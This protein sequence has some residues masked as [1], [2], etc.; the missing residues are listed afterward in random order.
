MYTPRHQA[1]SLLKGAVQPTSQGSM[2]LASSCWARRARHVRGIAVSR[3]SLQFLGRTP[4]QEDEC[5][6]R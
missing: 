2:C 5:A 1:E 3:A 4:G 6:A